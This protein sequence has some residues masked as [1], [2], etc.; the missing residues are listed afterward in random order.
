MFNLLHR[1]EPSTE[2]LGSKLF[3]E[4]TF[5]DV[6]QKD[7]DR[8]GSEVLIESPFITNRRLSSLLPTLQKLKDRKVRIVINT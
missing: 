7:L 3:N 5:Y 8:C 6:F 1:H 2:L 4:K